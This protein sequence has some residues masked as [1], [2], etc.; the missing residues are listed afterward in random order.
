MTVRE[1]LEPLGPFF[2]SPGNFSAPKAN[3][4]IEI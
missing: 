3:I 2:D 4:Q 1:N